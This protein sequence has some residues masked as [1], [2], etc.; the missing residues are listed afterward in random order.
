MPDE[1]PVISATGLAA[2]AATPPAPAGLSM[3]MGKH[4]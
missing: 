4:P 3:S 1:A 2:M